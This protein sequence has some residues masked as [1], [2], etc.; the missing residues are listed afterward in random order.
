[1]ILWKYLL[2]LNQEEKEQGFTLP[3]VIGFGLFMLSIGLVSIK[4]SSDSQINSQIQERTYQ[5]LAAA[6]VGITQFQEYLNGSPLAATIPDCNSRATDGS[7]SDAGSSMPSWGNPD[8]LEV[9]SPE[10]S[11]ELCEN[12]S[13]GTLPSD[14]KRLATNNQTWEL[15][16]PN[17]PEKGEYR[18]A[19]YSS[20]AGAGVFPAVGTL[21][22]EG[23]TR[24]VNRGTT[25][26]AVNIPIQ[27]STQ[28][29]N[30]IE[31]GL[32]MKYNGSAN[33]GSHQIR[34]SILIENTTCA[35]NDPNGGIPSQLANASPIRND[36]SGDPTG[37]LI[38]SKLE[39]P[40]TPSLPPLG[41]LND[42]SESDA[43]SKELP[44][45]DANGNVTDR[46]H[47]GAFHYL[48]PKLA[49][50]G[51]AS[52]NIQD[53]Q[54]V[55]FYVQG[56][57]EFSGSINKTTNSSS[58]NLQIYGNTT[59]GD[60]EGYQ[61]SNFKYGCYTN[62]SGACPTTVIQLKGTSEIK[63]FIHAPEA[64]SCITG[65]GSPTGANITGAIWVNQWIASNDV[66]GK[67]SGLGPCTGGGTKLVI[68]SVELD[69][70]GDLQTLIPDNVK[71]DLLKPIIYEVPRMSA[72]SNW[73]RQEIT[74]P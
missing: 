29:E 42:L 44:R 18:L 41:V 25:R 50:S 16:D 23:R 22:V 36:A 70:N 71:T 49:M 26:L 13:A 30:A 55:I 37:Q 58:K 28:Q 20:S 24:E 7:C 74:T 65:G 34:G 66:F 5:A 61:G 40:D 72:S 48:V 21:I 39:M 32:W 46:A 33:L 51:N 11:S 19:S 10:D 69:A 64:W 53:G 57:I 43:L 63:A 62:A 9:P 59:V 60:G 68:D 52:I 3:L 31:P 56:N 15:V 47:E 17:N 35:S 14:V 73:E 4:M 1:M 2:T 8:T 54:K 38:A 12:T 27:K 6:E 67:P 45:K